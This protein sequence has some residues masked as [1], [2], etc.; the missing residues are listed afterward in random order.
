MP[1]NKVSANEKIYEVGGVAERGIFTKEAQ[2]I[3]ASSQFRRKLVALVR[4]GRT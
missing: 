4:R 3:T 2:P 1:A